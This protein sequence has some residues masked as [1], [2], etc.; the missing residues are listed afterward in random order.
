MARAEKHE[1]SLDFVES[2]L[3]YLVDTGEKPMS[4]SGQPGSNVRQVT[5]HYE[6]YQVTVHNG[7]LLL[8][9]LSLEQ[10]GF[11]FVKHETKVKDFYAEPLLL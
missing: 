6:E 9:R 1:K 5:G 10:E 8:D 2:S 4:Y 7:R 11:I 3:N